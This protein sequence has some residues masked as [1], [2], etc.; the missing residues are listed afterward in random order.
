M[1]D[2]RLGGGSGHGHLHCPGTQLR[3]QERPRAGCS[4]ADSGPDGIGV[5]LP[6]VQVRG[7]WPAPC[8]VPFG[9]CAPPHTGL[10]PPCRRRP[11]RAPQSPDSVPVQAAACCKAATPART[12]LRVAT[13]A[14]ADT[15][16]A[17]PGVGTAATTSRRHLLRARSRLQIVNSTIIRRQYRTSTIVSRVACG[18]SA[19]MRCKPRLPPPTAAQAVP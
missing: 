17:G 4:A 2:M 10:Q 8:C 12:A 11:W 18:A 1:R 15:T 19:D 3:Q 13:R 16:T 14:H 6:R 7:P 5:L 9:G